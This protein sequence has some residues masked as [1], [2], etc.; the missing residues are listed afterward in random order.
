MRCCV[1]L[2]RLFSVLLI[3][4]LSLVNHCQTEEIPSYL[5]KIHEL[6]DTVNQRRPY[7]QEEQRNIVK[8]KKPKRYKCILIDDDE[9]NKKDTTLTSR[10]DKLKAPSFMKELKIK[11]SRKHSH[12]EENEEE[13]GSQYYTTTQKPNPP[14]YGL[15]AEDLDSFVYTPKPYEVEEPTES[16]AATTTASLVK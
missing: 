4:A 8:Q 3:I 2:S 15:P 11:A 9:E 14:F 10:L 1:P 5:A 6:R 12:D 16:P 7:L 13:I